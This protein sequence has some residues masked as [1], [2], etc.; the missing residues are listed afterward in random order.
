MTNQLG[1]YFN[2]DKKYNQKLFHTSHTFYT[3]QDNVLAKRMS[4]R[5]LFNTSCWFYTYQDNILEVEGCLLRTFL[6]RMF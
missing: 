2:V 4:V 3:Y 6:N 1:T 5:V